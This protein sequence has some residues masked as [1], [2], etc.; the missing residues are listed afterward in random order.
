MFRTETTVSYRRRVCAL[1]LALAPLAAVPAA[2]DPQCKNVHSHLVIQAEAV[3]TCGSP[4]GLCASA[5]LQGSLTA[6][7][8]FVGTSFVSTVDTPATGVV[9]LTGDN[10]FHTAN[11]DFTTKDAIVLST[12]GAGDF[13]EVDTVT[14]GTGDYAGATGVFT[15][16]GTFVNGVGSG[17]IEG[18]I[19]TP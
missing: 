7:T 18:E 17:V 6:V 14:G 1:I 5:T 3:P 12:T 16:T 10:T 9:V 4:I 15:A 8:D 13:A 11:G 19:C 2:A